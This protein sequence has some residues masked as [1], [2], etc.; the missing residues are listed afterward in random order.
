MRGTTK[1]TG[2]TNKDRRC[3][4]RAGQY[5]TNQ[6]LEN[7]VKYRN[8]DKLTREVIVALIDMIYIYEGNKVKIVFKYQYPFKA[9]MEYFENN[10][11]LLNIPHAK[12]LLGA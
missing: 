9:A 8:I 12:A 4:E 2:A 11:D 3:R 5:S 10:K 6:F 1:G 7:F